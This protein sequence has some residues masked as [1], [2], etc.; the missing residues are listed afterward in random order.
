MAGLV[1]A[2]HADVQG[3]GAWKKR[4]RSRRN[5]RRESTECRSRAD[6]DDRDEPGHDGFGVETPPSLGVTLFSFFPCKPLK[7]LKTA[8]GLFEKTLTFQ[9]QIWKKH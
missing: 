8:K 9:V 1:P 5:R 7:T 6:V 2:I 4:D 3:I